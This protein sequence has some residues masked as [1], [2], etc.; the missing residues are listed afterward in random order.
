MNNPNNLIKEIFKKQAKV[1]KLTPNNNTNVRTNPNDSAI[2]NSNKPLQNNK[3]NVILKPK[4]SFQE[5][6]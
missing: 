1:K 5:L 6:T 3:S 4:K 2:I